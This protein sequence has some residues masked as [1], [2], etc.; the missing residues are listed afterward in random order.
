M[1]DDEIRSIEPAPTGDKAADG[2]APWA[3][4]IDILMA[5][6]IKTRPAVLVFG[7]DDVHGFTPAPRPRAG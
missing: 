3:S 1:S 6:P 7:D 5:Q 2:A 4:L